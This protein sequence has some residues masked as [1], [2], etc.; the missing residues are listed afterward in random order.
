M[1]HKQCYNGKSQQGCIPTRVC[2]LICVQDHSLLFSLSI[3]LPFTCPLCRKIFSLGLQDF[4][5]QIT[6]PKLQT[7]KKSC[8]V[9]SGNHWNSQLFCLC[10]IEVAGIHP[11]CKIFQQVVKEEALCLERNESASPDLKGNG[12]RS[13]INMNCIISDAWCEDISCSFGSQFD[14]T[15]LFFYIPILYSFLV[16]SAS[17]VG[18]RFTPSAFG[19]L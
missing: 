4:L 1:L 16:W 18:W 8:P 5:P 15:F 17:P 3:L 13:T 19:H 6:N 2:K 9:C 10:I 12:P 7:G 11:E 14:S